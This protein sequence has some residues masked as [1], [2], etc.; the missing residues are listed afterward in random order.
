M[1]NNGFIKKL[2]NWFD[3]WFL[4]A[5]TAFFIAFIPLYPKIPLA[6]ILPGYIV[7]F[8]LEDVFIGVVVLWLGIQM[9]RRKVQWRTPLTAAIGLYVLCGLLANISGVVFTR[10]IPAEVLHI[11]KS[12]LHWARYIQYFSL[13]FIGYAAV[14]TRKQ[15]LSLVILALFTV[16]SVGLY[17]YGQKH[18][19]WPVYSTMNRE[20]SKG[21]RLYLGPYARVQ[22]TFA[23]HYDLGAYLVILLPFALAFFFMLGKRD[24]ATNDVRA[25]FILPLRIVSL[26][27]WFVGLWLL[28][29]S[30]SRASFIGYLMGTG[31][32]ILIWAWRF[33]NWKWFLTRSLFFFGI[34]AYMLVFVGDL[35]TRFA[36]LINEEKYP[37]LHKAFVSVTNL[38]NT[39]PNFLALVSW[40]P[41][42]PQNGKSTDE[43]EDELN[44]I[45]M[46]TSDT[47]PT[48]SRPNDVVVDVPLQEFEVG[49]PAATLAGTL[50]QQG[51]KLVEQRVYSQCALERSLSLCIRLETLWP[52]A[53]RGFF[54]N[55]ALGSGYA[56]LT[57][58]SVIQFTEADSTD[59][60]FLRTLGETGALGFFFFYGAVGLGLW[61]TWRAIRITRDPLIVALALASF[62]G[63]IGLLVN[64]VYIDVFASSKVAYTFWMLQGVVLALLV[65]EGIVA[66]RFAFERKAASAQTS[67]LSQLLQAIESKNQA[68]YQD[69]KYLSAAKRSAKQRKGKKKGQGRA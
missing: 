15:A 47:Q 65:R 32:V 19:F 39:R 45:G 63:S 69:S 64:A 53:M 52:Q 46:T 22:S 10:T 23:G 29:M 68:R 3:N 60:N 35:S 43:L 58:S 20:F 2:W 54:S 26:L 13:Y 18:W 50:V 4:L 49:D 66:Q 28:V 55:P 30:A 24:T 42:P 34:S 31:L 14:K 44:D 25:R 51:D 57:K 9:L 12:M 38:S 48:T 5:A 27:T 6:D 1:A 7:R 59:N 36:Q 16:L 41:K 37:E 11:G 62:A 17:G 40:R 61:W 8:R 67:Q 21:V 33:T 56:T